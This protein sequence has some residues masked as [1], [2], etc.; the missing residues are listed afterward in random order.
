MPNPRNNWTRDELIL[1]INLYCKIPF[2]KIHHRNPD[3]IQLGNLLGRT[4]SAVSWKLANLANIDP[5]LDRK[6]AS[7]VGKLD[8]AVWEEYFADWDGMAYE[9]ECRLAALMDCP[10]EELVPEELLVDT[11]P[12]PPGETREAVVRQRVNQ[13]FFR[14]MVLASYDQRCCITGLAIPALLNAGHI[15]PWSRDASARTNPRNGLCLNALHDRA[16]DRGL[17]TVDADHRV[18]V[19]R[20]VRELPEE[21]AAAVQAVHGV[22]LRMPK[23]FLPD[24]GYLAFHREQVFEA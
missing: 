5:A 6:G 17:I 20:S 9:S 14:R 24:P 13:G 8:R 21:D 2:G 18:V 7:N 1:A 19:S 10:V 12:L 16:F 3:L 4:P 22:G 11:V 23:R 15:V